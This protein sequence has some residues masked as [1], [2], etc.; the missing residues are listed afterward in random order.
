MMVLRNV[1]LCSRL[2]IIVSEIQVN[3]SRDYYSFLLYQY[4]IIITWIGS[5][6]MFA[7]FRVMLFKVSNRCVNFFVPRGYHEDYLKCYCDCKIIYNWQFLLTSALYKCYTKEGCV[8]SCY[9]LKLV[10]CI[11]IRYS[12]I[13]RI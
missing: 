13:M 4:M 6:Y 11:G 1:I 8:L 9:C 10:L 3:V 2:T 12:S 7:R 5:Q